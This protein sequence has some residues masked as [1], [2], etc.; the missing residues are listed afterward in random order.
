[1]LIFDSGLWHKA[2]GGTNREDRWSICNYYGPWW[3]KP[4]FRFTDIL[5]TRRM[6]KLNYNQKA[7]T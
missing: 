7:K 6:K 2:G 1:M 5:G 3:M 4:Y